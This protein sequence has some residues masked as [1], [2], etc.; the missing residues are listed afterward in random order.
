MSDTCGCCA[1][2]EVAVPVS[3]VNPPG[4]SALIY[5]AGTYATFFET[6]LARLTRVPGLTTRDL[7]DPSIA[8]LDAWAVVADVLT[9]YQER[10]ANEGY[11]P[12]ARERRSV[13]ELTRLIGYR[14][15]PGVAASVRLAFTVANGFAGTL[16]AGTRAQ[17]SAPGQNPQ[18]FETS[19]AL[20]AR[21]A[22]NVL[23][24]RLTRPQIITP[25]PGVPPNLVAQGKATAKDVTPTAADVID[26]V[27]FDGVTTALK[28]GNALIFAFGSGAGEQYVRM[29]QAVD[30]QGAQAR[31]EIT[32]VPDPRYRHALVLEILLAQAQFLFPGSDIA[33][34]VAA[35]LTVLLGNLQQGLAPAVGVPLL[36]ATL[37]SIALQRDIANARGFTRVSAYLGQLV[38]ALQALI[39]EETAGGA[40]SIF[41]TNPPPP[42][43]T[44]LPPE[45]SGSPL[46]RLDAI[47]GALSLPASIQPSSALQ[48]GRSIAQS[49]APESDAAI[50]LIAALNPAAAGTLYQAWSA[51]A[52]P[53]SRLQVFA[54]RVKATL[55]AS[56][57]AGPATIT[58]TPGKGSDTSTTA[59]G[60]VSISSMWKPTPSGMPLGT[61]ALD[62]AYDHIVAGSWVAVDRPLL[63]ANLQV[64]GRVTTVH[65]A[66]AVRTGTMDTGT[67]FSAKVSIVSLD[68][69][70]LSDAN[71][72]PATLL[73]TESLLR[74][75]VVYA[76]AEPLA[77]C[78]EPLDTDVEGDAIDLAAL[79]AG[80]EPGRWIIVSG[81]RTDVRGTSGVAAAELA[82]VAGVSQQGSATQPPLCV[83]FPFAK[84]PFTKVFYT[85][86]A[87]ANGDRLVVGQ[88][89]PALV[90]KRPDIPLPTV[91][92]QQFCNQVELA[93]GVYVHAYV[94]SAAE[95]AGEFPSFE[96]ML[97]DPQTNVPFPRG[98]L[99]Q[100]RQGDGLAAV[101]ISDEKL[102]TVLT[103]ANALAY[104]Y[105]RGSVTIYGNVVDATHGQTTGEVLGNGDAARAF[106]SYALGQA[107]LTYVSA[108]TPSGT[109]S[110][111]QVRVN[112]LLWH[113]VND[114]G[115]AEPAQRVYVTREDDAHKTTVTFGNGVHG[116]RLPTGTA[117]LKATYRYG[118]G[119]AGNVDAG[120]ISQLA[121]H[122]LGAQAVVNPLPATGGADPDTMDQA[123]TNAPSAVMALDRLVS[124]RDY[125]DFARTYA[126]IGKAVAARVSDGR[127][128][129][130][131]V[132]VAGGGDIPIDP[133]SDLY[134]NLVTSL[135]TYGD[136]HQPVDVDVR[137]V[138]LIVMSA[139]VALLP[140]YAWE[141]VVPKIR[142]A[143]LALFAFD[144]RALAQTAFL[145]EAVLAVQAV[146]G[147]AYVDV[148]TFDGVAENISAAQLASLGRTLKL[149]PY[150]AAEAARIDPAVTPGAAPRILPAELVFM[151][152]DIPDT[153]I[154]TEA[155]A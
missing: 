71:A 105:D 134:R 143:L 13:L 34:H 97:V 99:E 136:P 24:P 78:E 148:T 109:A 111:L 16:P 117:N 106:P 112:E 154:L 85:T 110:T 28:P 137:R 82:M 64:T 45:P 50:R 121:T 118:L 92:N 68:P 21:E 150:V 88:L 43:I 142:A 55:F 86:G 152:P 59:F 144:A 61:I 48:L 72:T 145:S 116:A 133:S 127:R 129:V 7:A 124:V 9:F 115:G 91:L 89:D 2:T 151:T 33:A 31:T 98:K 67:G 128:Q 36:R 37:P 140:D 35:I 138:K 8:L 108:P 94:P 95:R 30:A 90:Q 107:P 141:S 125:A 101:R 132:T 76:Q 74:D 102:H 38:R 155:G 83:P 100:K 63:D 27:Y 75:T 66:T 26:T 46:A 49:F 60:P 77:L 51:V 41:A 56:N 10:I 93:P 114:L 87:D 126:G 11:L 5:R 6:M 131:H 146:D 1:G 96:G 4:Q 42:T 149:R 32:L 52:T 70:W 53:M 139:T 20:D 69:P 39:V 135:Q 81:N 47:V 40:F 29:V 62:A 84:P 3:E 79:Y 12:T 104:S 25:A 54:A 44:A 23:P 58:H 19:A 120:Q 123:R 147:V 103:L 113:E 119:K 122:P 130:V 73:D 22:W 18:F 14:L 15:R 65:V 80:L 57:Y 17:S 153:L